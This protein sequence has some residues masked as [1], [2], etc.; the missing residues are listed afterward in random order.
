M[1]TGAGGKGGHNSCGVC[2][3]LSDWQQPPQVS[4]GKLYCARGWVVKRMGGSKGG[5]GEGGITLFD[6]LL[7]E[8]V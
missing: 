8:S 1:V 5:G 7:D 2:R 3:A 4:V 6:R